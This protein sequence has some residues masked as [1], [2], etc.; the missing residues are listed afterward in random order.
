MDIN[1]DV[2]SDAIERKIQAQT[3]VEHTAKWATVYIDMHTHNDKEPL[4]NPN[5]K[6]KIEYCFKN[7]WESGGIIRKLKIQGVIREKINE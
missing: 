3:G 1:S 6:F 2:Y 5:S 7:F 4:E